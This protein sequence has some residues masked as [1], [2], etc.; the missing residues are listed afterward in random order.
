MTPLVLLH[1]FTGSPAS[2]DAVVQVLPP[3][4]TAFRPTLLGHGGFSE[5]AARAS[6]GVDTS[7]E[8]V[9]P[10][11]EELARLTRLL[12]PEPVH[13]CGYSL[14]ARLALGIALSHPARIARLTLVSGQPGLT[15][16]PARAERRGSD[17]AWCAL[18][19]ASGIEAFVNAWEAQPLFASQAALPEAARARQRAIRLAHDPIGLA[20]SLRVTGLAE[21]PDYGPRLR[22]LSVPVTLL[23]GELD[24]KFLAFGREMSARLPAA[25]LRIAPSAGHDLL[26]ER[27]D[28]VAQE[29]SNEE[30]ANA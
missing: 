29:L 26:L 18:L 12:P 3:G 4:T 1:G 21:M 10:F 22:E 28:L 11:E 8:R 27:P 17:A 5:A 6:E 13:L 19:E 7:D 24:A 15:S 20:R 23:V 16:D 9:Y 14:G 30:S 2:W 25:R